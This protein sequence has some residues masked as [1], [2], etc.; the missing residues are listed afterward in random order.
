LRNLDIPFV[1]DFPSA[2]KSTDHVVD[3]IF[4]KPVSK[5]VISASLLI[6]LITGFSFS[7][8][9]REPFPAVIEALESTSVPVTSVDAPS[10]WNI[11]TGPPK[12][13]PG[14]NFNPAA[15]VSLTAPK[16]LVAWF[17]GRH[18]L[19]GRQVH[20]Y[21]DITRYHFQYWINH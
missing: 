8:E 4:G 16:P 6:L 1:D 20:N 13:G 15:L 3:A 10:S 9:V 21:S 11:E 7:G 5:Y 14:K 2:L 18:F 17:K 19:G 12:D